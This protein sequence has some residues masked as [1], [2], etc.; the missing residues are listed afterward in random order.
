MVSWN[1]LDTLSSYKELADVKPACLTEVMSGDNGAERVKN[2]SI[3]MAT[4]LSY[5][6]ASKQVDENVLAALEK[7]ADEAQ[8]ADKFK[9]LYNGEVVNTGEKRLVLH[10]MTRGQLGDAVEADGVDKRTFYKT[11]QE[12]IAEFANKVHNGEITNAAGEKFTTVVQIGIGGS[13]LGPRAMYIALENWAKKNN[14]FKMEAK[15]ISNVDP[16][17]AAA[18]LASTDVAHSIFVL[19]SKSGTTLETL[20]N[21]SFVKDALKK[22]GLDPSKHMIA[23]TSETSPLAKS[24]DYLD[25]FFMD[26]YIG[27]RF[28]STSS[29]GGAV[30]SLA[31]GP[32]VFAEF[33]DGAAEED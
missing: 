28:S 8:L 13:D 27:G 21:E 20:T 12:R 15:F 4:G 31:F 3:P 6:Y 14:A 23:V 9:A 1:N 29:V 30:L 22:A 16:D 11:Q 26:D 24:D 7:L 25:A 32:E 17:D 33:L 10:H 2:Y 5:N 18:V 19:V